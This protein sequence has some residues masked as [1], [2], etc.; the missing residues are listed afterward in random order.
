MTGLVWIE[1]VNRL[2]Q[3]GYIHKKTQKFD[4]TEA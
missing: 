3:G 2:Y 1:I 4:L